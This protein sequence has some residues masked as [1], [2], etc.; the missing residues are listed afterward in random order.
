MWL[1]GGGGESGSLRAPADLLL[2]SLHPLMAAMIEVG[3]LRE[4]LL[5]LC[6]GRLS[7]SSLS[8]G[9]LKV[10]AGEAHHE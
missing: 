5:M 10:L 9:V 4:P 8:Q 3:S 7:H 6:A 1:C 2:Q